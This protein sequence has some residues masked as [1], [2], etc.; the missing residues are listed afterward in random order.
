MRTNLK[1][2][3]FVVFFIPSLAQAAL[4]PAAESMRRLKTIAESH[5]VFE[6]IGSA[7]LVTG[8]NQTKEGYV[9]TTNR[10]RLKVYLRETNLKDIDPGMI[11][12]PKLDVEIGEMKC[13]KRR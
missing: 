3:T 13:Q 12:P 4:P 1:L 10:C 5:L 8:I 2:F 9:V 7:D 6:K 11:G